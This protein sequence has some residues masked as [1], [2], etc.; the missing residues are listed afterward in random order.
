MNTILDVVGVRIGRP[1]DTLS[2]PG[3]WWWV[4][5]LSWPPPPG[6]PACH[7][8]NIMSYPWFT[9]DFISHL[10]AG[11]DDAELSPRDLALLEAYLRQPMSFAKI[12]SER[13]K[14]GRSPTQEAWNKLKLIRDFNRGLL[15]GEAEKREAPAPAV[16]RAKTSRGVPLAEA[17]VK[18]R[19]WLLKHAGDD[20][21]AITRDAVAKGT[22]VSPAQVSRTA[23]WKAFGERRDAEKKPRPKER[24]LTDQML[25][26]L[27]PE[28]QQP[29]E[30]T[31]LI[32]EQ[33]QDL[34]EEERQYKRRSENRS[35]PF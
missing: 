25:A 31:S 29:H 4:G 23:V 26:V 27:P 14:L 1:P 2:G 9:S 32:E 16:A 3:A 13:M 20:P 5:F 35:K 15:P 21:A 19:E 30:L 11:P 33:Q 6:W 17:E 24:R 28:A 10:L 8:S 12:Q 7:E 22:G 34:A 18:V